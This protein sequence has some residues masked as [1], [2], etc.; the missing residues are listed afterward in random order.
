MELRLELLHSVG[1][2]HDL[3]LCFHRLGPLALRHLDLWRQLF[4]EGH[5]DQVLRIL[6]VDELRIKLSRGVLGAA[7][8]R[9]WMLVENSIQLSDVLVDLVQLVVE[10][11]WHLD[12]FAITFGS[13]R[14]LTA[15]VER[16]CIPNRPFLALDT[17]PLL[18]LCVVD[19][20]HQ[21]LDLRVLLLN[22]L[23]WLGLWQ[24]FPECLGHLDEVLMMPLV[25]L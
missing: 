21:V 17:Q 22:L 9:R 10:V 18:Q 8:H 4:P 25:N 15:K 2:N 3:P 13:F 19:R 20:H 7:V 16:P 6:S 24:W 23:R 11:T 5:L 12:M 1:V 14:Y